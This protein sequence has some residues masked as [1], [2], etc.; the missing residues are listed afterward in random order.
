M[1][2]KDKKLN[3]FGFFKE[4]ASNFGGIIDDLFGESLADFSEKF[5]DLVRPPGSGNEEDFL[6]LCIKCGKCIKACPFIALQPVIHANEFDRGT[7]C[8]RVA[9]SYCRFCKDFPCISA[10]PSGALNLKNKT[11]KIATAL[12]DAEKCLRTSKISCD[13]CRQRCDYGAIGLT[14][15]NAE[16]EIIVNKCTGCGACVCVCPV[17]PTTAVKLIPER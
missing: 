4:I 17:T 6:K 8:L 14:A 1:S 11:K 12:I 5:P 16:P 9:A 13:A 10:C 15:E 7:P 2:K 3:R